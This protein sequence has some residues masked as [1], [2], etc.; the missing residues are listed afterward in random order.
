MCKRPWVQSLILGQGDKKKKQMM[1]FE[2]RGRITSQ[3]TWGPIKAVK[4][5]EMDF[6]LEASERTSSAAILILYFC[7]PVL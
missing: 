3:G 4:V 1:C 5:K 6:S 7:S 2:N